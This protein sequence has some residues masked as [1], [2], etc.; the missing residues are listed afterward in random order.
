MIRAN[1]VLEFTRFIKKQGKIP[2]NSEAPAR[3][4]K[5]WPWEIFRE[6]L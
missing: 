1:M 3:N 4:A 6:V 5:Y 2:N